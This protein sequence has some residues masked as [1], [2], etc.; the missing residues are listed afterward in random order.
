[1]STSIVLSLLSQIMPVQCSKDTSE[2]DFVTSLIVKCKDRQIHR[3]M[4]V[5]GD[6]FGPTMRI[7]NKSFSTNFFSL[8]Y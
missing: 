3:S 7:K 5:K 1:M 2:I 8:I 6:Y 4:C